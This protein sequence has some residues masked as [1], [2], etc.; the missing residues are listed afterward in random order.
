M[1]TLQFWILV[2]ISTLVSA[3]MIKQ[4]FL[5]RAMDNKLQDLAEAQQA[6]ETGPGY[7]NAW[8]HLA[9]RLFQ[10]SHEGQDVALLQ[11]LKNADVE[12]RSNAAHPPPA[13]GVPSAETNS[14][15]APVVPSHTATP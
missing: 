5:T 3:L 13:P 10:A 11:V 7:E 14:L 9:M 4:I 1:R 8:K 15:Q 6:A 2:I 12:V